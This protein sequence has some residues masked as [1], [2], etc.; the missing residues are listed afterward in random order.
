[1]KKRK[2]NAAM[3]A[4]VRAA[5]KLGYMQKGEFKLL[6]KKKSPEYQ[7]YKKELEKIL[8]KK[9]AKKPACPRKPAKKPSCPK[10]PA[11]KPACPKK[12]ATKPA[13]KSKKVAKP[14]KKQSPKAAVAA[15][16][17]K[18]ERGGAM[19]DEQIIKIRQDE[20][21]RTTG[22]GIFRPAIVYGELPVAD[23]AKPALHGEDIGQQVAQNQEAEGAGI[24]GGLVAAIAAPLQAVQAWFAPDEKKAEVAKELEKA[25]DKIEEVQ[26]AV[27]RVATPEEKKILNE[28]VKVIEEALVEAQKPCGEMR[29]TECRN[30]NQCFWDETRGLCITRADM[31]KIV[32][33]ELV[34]TRYATHNAAR[35]R[36]NARHAGGVNAAKDLQ[37]AL[38]NGRNQLE[39]SPAFKLIGKPGPRVRGGADDLRESLKRRTEE[40]PRTYG[41]RFIRTPYSKKSVSFS[42]PLEQVY[43]YEYETPLPTPSPVQNAP[44]F[45][46]ELIPAVFQQEPEPPAAQLSKRQTRG[47][48]KAKAICNQIP[49]KEICNQSETCTWNKHLGCIDK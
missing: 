5:K 43:E 14:A 35:A 11:K 27:E 16:K 15:K 30:N 9:P 31:E 10:K 38:A 47:G 3:K 40:P 44:G 20:P 45:L 12:K 13:T 42:S 46:E 22:G 8:A 36:K 2:P 34:A 37:V 1:M 28:G 23:V 33:A 29:K 48:G 32:K 17:T 49:T 18:K 21:A 19:D 26:P 24:F 4:S 39:V 6:P 41:P 7:E 25:L